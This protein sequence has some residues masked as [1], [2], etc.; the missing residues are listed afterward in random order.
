MRRGINPILWP[1]LALLALLL[2]NLIWT[3]GFFSIEI[4]DGRFYGSLID[5]LNRGAPVM[6]V[7]LGMTLVIATR[8]VDLSVG[9]V[10]AIAGAIAALL[11]T[12]SHA[13]LWQVVAT[14]LGACLFMGLWNGFLVAFF[15]IQPMVATLILMVSGRGIAQLLTDGQIITFQDPGLASVSG[16]SLFGFPNPVVWAA[17]AFVL[18]A[19]LMRFTAAGLFVASVGDNEKASELSGIPVRWVKVGTYVI[20]ALGAGVAGLIVCSDTKAADANNAGL[21]LELD[22]ILAVVAGGTMMTGGRFTLVGSILGALILQTLTTTI[23]TKG[24]PVQWTLVVKALA[25]LFVCLLQSEQFR[26]K[27]AWRR[28]KA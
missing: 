24:V 27:L 16:G 11:V 1:A 13:P 5:V 28:A 14:V 19:S 9:A 6:L 7:A 17:L 15:D 8:G 4:R 20:C 2:A 18:V 21:Y 25:V 23:L 3:P 10:M 12:K 22:A 26:A